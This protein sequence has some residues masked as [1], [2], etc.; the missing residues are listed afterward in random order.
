M[1]YYLQWNH[2]TNHLPKAKVSQKRWSY[3]WCH[4][5]RSLAQCIPKGRALLWVVNIFASSRRG[6]LVGSPKYIS[7][8]Q[9][10]HGILHIVHCILYTLCLVDCIFAWSRGGRGDSRRIYSRW[11]PSRVSAFFGLQLSRVFIKFLSRL[12]NCCFYIWF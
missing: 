8:T 6:W 4:W 10:L 5:W 3:P 1:F 7:P 9:V 2:N 12:I 11:F